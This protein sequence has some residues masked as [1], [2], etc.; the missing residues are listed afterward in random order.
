MDG[1]SLFILFRCISFFLF[2]FFFQIMSKNLG[3][4]W[5]FFLFCIKLL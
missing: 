3:F 2:A 5:K 4:I 1:N